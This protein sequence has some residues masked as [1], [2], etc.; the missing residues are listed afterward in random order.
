MY[1]EL[2]STLAATKNIFNNNEL[3]SDVLESMYQSKIKANKEIE[4][5]TK[6]YSDLY[7]TKKV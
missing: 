4:K 5:M 7:K 1:N 2:N 3:N 6:R